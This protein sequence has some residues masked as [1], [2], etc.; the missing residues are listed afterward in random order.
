MFAASK[1]RLGTQPSL[2]IDPAQQS[3]Q[4]GLEWD[5]K[6]MILSENES[7]FKSKFHVTYIWYTQ[8]SD[9][10]KAWQCDRVNKDAFLMLGHSIFF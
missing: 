5:M 8:I 3:Q 7:S 6:I 1:N 4:R 10:Q 9:P 2:P